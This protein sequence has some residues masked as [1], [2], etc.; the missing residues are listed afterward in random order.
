MKNG[1]VFIYEDEII[2]FVKSY[3]FKSGY[4]I[5]DNKINPNY[6]NVNLTD[7]IDDAFKWEKEYQIDL[8]YDNIKGLI[9]TDTT[10]KSIFKMNSNVFRRYLK[11]KKLK[12][13]C[14]LIEGISLLQK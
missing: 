10:I 12:E 4:R 11:I 7:N 2:L 9:K 8:A 13:K 6:L 1:I 3:S 5:I 14:Q